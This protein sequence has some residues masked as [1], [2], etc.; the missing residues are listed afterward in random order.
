MYVPESVTESIGSPESCDINPMTEN[1]TKPA[2]ILVA[3]LIKTMMI[4]SLRR[5]RNNR[6]YDLELV[7][8]LKMGKRCFC[9][10]SYFIYLCCHSVFALIHHFE[11]SLDLVIILDLIQQ[12]VNLVYF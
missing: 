7:I 2:N 9:C 11:E 3:P 6:M 12:K 10:T 4:P 1:M 8:I 5:E